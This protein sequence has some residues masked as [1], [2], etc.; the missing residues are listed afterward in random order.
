MH[1]RR[2]NVRTVHRDDLVRQHDHTLL[3]TISII[4]SIVKR[5]KDEHLNQTLSQ[6]GMTLR[7]PLEEEKLEQILSLLRKTMHHIGISSQTEAMGGSHSV[8]EEIRQMS[9]IHDL[10]SLGLR[11]VPNFQA[12]LCTEH[13]DIIGNQRLNVTGEESEHVAQLLDREFGLGVPLRD[14][15]Y[16]WRWRRGRCL[17]DGHGRRSAHGLRETRGGVWGGKVQHAVLCLHQLQLIVGC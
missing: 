8:F 12:R 2:D 6:F 15:R 4:T 5:E 17:I 13:N 7:L 1:R 16:V 11:R 14:L 10:V 3:A 9:T